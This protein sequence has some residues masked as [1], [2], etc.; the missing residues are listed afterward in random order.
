MTTVDRERLQA[1]LSQELAHFAETHP[2]SRELYERAR[3]S[4]L[5]GVPMHWMVRW[6]GSFP[7]FVQDAAGAHFTD[8]DGHRYL[9]LCLGDTGAMTGHAP[10]AA[11]AAIVERVRH[12]VTFMLP[13]EDAIWVGEELGRRFG[14]P[15]WQFALTEAAYA[16]TIPL[17]ERFAAGVGAAL[18]RFDLPW[19]VNRLGCRVEYWFRPASRN[20]GEAA[21]IDPDLDRYMHLA[22]LNRG[23]LTTPFHNMALIAP[24][25]TATD[26]DYHT[27]VF[28]E[29]VSALVA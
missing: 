14:L 8:V 25:A 26:I 15:F 24:D 21:A 23:I 18:R 5:G 22:A 20:G 17:A 29:I 19:H 11:V 7:I 9:D 1:L 4:L 2:R 27:R 28:E 10:A 13:T 6:A 16:R 12:G 3:A